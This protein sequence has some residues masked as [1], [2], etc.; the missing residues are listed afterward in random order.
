MRIPFSSLPPDARLW[1]FAA[2]R[3]LSPDEQDRL[4]G[5]VD[6]FLD[7]WKAHGHPLSAARD[8]RYGQFLLVA[9][10]ESQEGASGCSID[11]MTRSLTELERHLRVELINHAPV[12]YRTS[13]GI[14]RTTRPVFGE[15]VKA[16]EITPET[17]VFNNTLTRVGDLAERWEVPASASWHGK[18][19]FRN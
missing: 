19:F 6:E 4:L 18:A 16:G 10:D 14:A 2:E 9:V 1:I 13:D 7:Q 11:A 17:I 12:L 5:V 8:L 15:R 3:R